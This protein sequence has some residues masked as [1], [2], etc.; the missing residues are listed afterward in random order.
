MVSFFDGFFLLDDDGLKEKSSFL[1]RVSE[2]PPQDERK[3]LLISRKAGIKPKG[4][5]L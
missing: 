5:V 3:M 1:E 2:S 4:L